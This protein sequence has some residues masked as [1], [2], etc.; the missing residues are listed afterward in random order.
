M[1]FD[2]GRASSPGWTHKDAYRVP[3][4]NT[5]RAHANPV[6]RIG[7]PSRYKFHGARAAQIYPLQAKA[8]AMALGLRLPF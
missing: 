3:T 4:A 6:G 2:G 8:R 1:R 7:I 5:V